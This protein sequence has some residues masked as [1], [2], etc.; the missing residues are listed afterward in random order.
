[1]TE[2]RQNQNAKLYSGDGSHLDVDGV[3]WQAA[4]QKD[5]RAL[6]NY[7][8]FEPVGSEILQFRFLNEDLRIDFS[9][10]CLLRCHSGAWQISDAPLLTLATV[11]YLKDINAVY[12][13]GKD[14]VGVKDLKQGHFFTGP[15]EL[16]TAPLL[17]RFGND[18]DGFRKAGSALAGRPMNMAD[19]AFQVM[20]FPRVPLY[21]L[22]WIGDAEFEP[23]LQ[24]LFD[25]SI[26]EFLAADAIWAL[27][28][29]VIM[30]FAR[31]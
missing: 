6:C 11:M 16:R 23:R 27:V 20:P 25:R 8:F 10:R 30:V 12:P 19:A 4:A 9:K 5:R 18:L 29:C 14:L 2:H 13:L 3:Y 1:M 31:I 17:Q 7:T 28:N 26:E 24:V 15:H 22:L 21:F